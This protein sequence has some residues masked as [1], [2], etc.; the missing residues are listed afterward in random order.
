MKS[1][2]YK[3][4]PLAFAILPALL[5]TACG[6]IEKINSKG[7][8]LNGH[9]GVQLKSDSN[10][11]AATGSN[12]TL[13]QCSM[14]PNVI[15]NQPRSC[16]ICGM[17][18]QP[19]EPFEAEGIAG[20]AP[21]MLTDVQQQLINIRTSTVEHRQVSLSVQAPG[22]IEHDQSHVF[23]VSAWTAGR[24][25]K[26]YADEEET[27]VGI[28]DPL[29]SIY[30]PTLYAAMQEYI[31]LRKGLLDETGLIESARI[32]MRQLGLNEA[33]IESLH[34]VNK[35]P[36]AIDILSPVSGKI[37]T[38]RIREGEYVKEG[39]HL[40][41]VIDLS[42]LWL[43]T[44]VYEFELPFISPGQQIVATTP[45]VPNEKF[46][47][48]I[49]LVNHHID[50]STRTARLRVLFDD[51]EQI[52]LRRVGS[53]GIIHHEHRLLPDMW[54]TVS[55]KKDLGARLVIPRSAIFDTG[56]RQ[57]VFVQEQK[58]LFVPKVIVTG[59]VTEYGVVVVEG[60]ELGQRVVTDG[61]FLLDSESQ[62]KA[63][64]SGEGEIGAKQ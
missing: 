64:A 42:Q 20:R 9:D 31:D 33:Q 37:M 17:D 3:N 56:R 1:I 59:P 27:D 8:S 21:V 50:P 23:T 7:G 49:S 44:E 39:D 22:V 32:R 63:V 45:A 24:I 2:R 6:L 4:L 5:L 18:L 52:M 46:F 47:G 12:E 14:H 61:T 55:I 13:Y 43:M 16:P 60:L 25:E 58:G 41:T 40:Y 10:D 48:T 19:V 62:L 29:Y 53:D 54:M 51:P 36:A 34:T 38:K 15:G 57:H 30:S 35:A 28:G 26:L 11:L